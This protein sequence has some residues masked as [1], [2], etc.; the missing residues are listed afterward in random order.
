MTVQR[1]RDTLWLKRLTGIEKLW[2]VARKGD[3]EG[4]HQ[5]RVASRRIREALPIL[6]DGNHPHRARRMQRTV[7]SLTRSLGPVRE[8]DVSLLLLEAFE[9]SHPENQSA[10]QVVRQAVVD[11]RKKLQDVLREHLDSTSAG[12]LSHKLTKATR[13]KKKAG[14]GHRNTASADGGG[15]E[16]RWR[17]ALAARIVRRSK[18]LEQCIEHAGALYAPDRL[19]GVRVSVKK[20][21]Y[22]LELGQEARLGRLTAA[23]R[24]LKKMQ[25]NLGELHDREML[26][27]H[28]R[29]VHAEQGHPALFESLQRFTRLLEEETRHYHAQFVVHREDL[30][31]LCVN[32]R[33]QVSD[34]VPIGRPARRRP[35]KASHRRAA[36]PHLAADRASLQE[37]TTR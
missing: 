10:I 7:R 13:R 23:I 2:K 29:T 19:H 12:E 17:L 8:C 3:P 6:A 22:A 11:E 16:E 27:D 28:V 15:S 26:L 31:K 1:L 14:A 37:L 36:R 4:V 20:L 25:D 34:V 9:Q 32:A 18:Q 30:A 5:L 35:A 24:L 21:R 33:Q